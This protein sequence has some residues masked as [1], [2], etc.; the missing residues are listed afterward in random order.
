MISWRTNPMLLILNRIIPILIISIVLLSCDGF[1]EKFYS[2]IDASQKSII[3]D[4][5]DVTFNLSEVTDFEWSKMLHISGNE[6][7]PV[8]NFEIEPILNYETTD[9]ET[10]KNRF[11]F[12]TPENELIIKEVEHAHSPAYEIEFCTSDLDHDTEYYQWLSKEECE[13]T[14]VSN[15]DVAGTG[16]VFLIPGCDTIHNSTS[17]PQ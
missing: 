17:S 8:Y 13:F 2:K 11:Y 16:T 12:L 3:E 1:E 10:N 6:S 14:L 7:V 5:A 15:T 4:N 9:L